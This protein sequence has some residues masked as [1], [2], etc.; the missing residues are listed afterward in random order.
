MSKLS[1]ECIIRKVSKCGYW[2]WICILHLEW[3]MSY[4]QSEG[5]QLLTPYHNMKIKILKEFQGTWKLRQT[6][7]NAN[8]NLNLNIDHENQN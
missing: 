5:W 4:G 3:D 2:K 1:L 6:T 7:T 8:L